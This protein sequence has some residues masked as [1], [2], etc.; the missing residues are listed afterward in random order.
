MTTTYL[1]TKTYHAVAVLVGPY[2]E[3]PRGV[4]DARI[5]EALEV[6][7]AE[8]ERESHE[9]TAVLA[10]ESQSRR[11]HNEKVRVLVHHTCRMSLFSPSQ[12]Y[13]L[14]NSFRAPS[15]SYGRK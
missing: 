2:E 11:I 6:T 1:F 3:A 4:H 15:V 12:L 9:E 5:E 14:A 13:V 10:F 8:L 7:L